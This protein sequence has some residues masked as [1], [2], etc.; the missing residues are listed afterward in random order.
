MLAIAVVLALCQTQAPKALK[1]GAGNS[2]NL[3]ISWWADGKR[4]AYTQIDLGDPPKF[5]PDNVHAFIVSA[6]GKTRRQLDGPALAADFVNDGKSLIIT[7]RVGAKNTQLLRYDLATNKVFPISPDNCV[8]TCPACSPVAD[9]IA[10][11]SDRDG[12]DLQI[13]LMHKDGTGLKK[14][15]HGPGKAY[16]PNWSMDGKQLVYYR[17]LGDQKDQIWTMN[18]DGSN[19][20]HISKSDEHN[21]YPAFLKNGD[22]SYTNVVGKHPRRSIIVD[23]SGNLKSVWMYDTA[24]M[25]WSPKGDKV[26]F[27]AGGFPK[28]AVY[29]ANTDGSDPVMVSA[30]AQS[31]A[32]IRTCQNNMQT[33]AMA[34]QAYKVRTRAKRYPLIADVATEVGP[35]RML[36]DLAIVPK[37]PVDPANR[38]SV[39]PVGD[40][41]KVECSD[42]SHGRWE[43]GAIVP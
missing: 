14:I 24:Y 37:C 17:E 20:K 42:K 40:S 30:P 16:N 1:T 27:F 7:R 35:G 38:Y 31:D 15:T 8:S 6:D 12:D 41:F 28:T 39:T 25:K 10:F 3:S 5:D 9:W 26:A 32:D 34:V 4:L 13:F 19:E 33:I 22:I 2:G 29:I 21:F 23:P 11:S 18:A 36:E 43:K